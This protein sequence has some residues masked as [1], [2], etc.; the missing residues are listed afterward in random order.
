VGFVTSGTSSPTLKQ[1]IALALV[2]SQ[3]AA[4]GKSWQI[5]IRRSAK[6]AEKVTL[7][8]VK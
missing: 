5:E 7:P 4:T 1:G 6:D 2:D 8:F 3:S